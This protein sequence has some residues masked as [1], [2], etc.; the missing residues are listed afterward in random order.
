MIGTNSNQELR[1]D[2]EYMS[3][4]CKRRAVAFRAVFLTERSGRYPRLAR[5]LLPLLL[6][7]TMPMGLTAQTTSVVEGTVL[8]PLG[9]GIVGAEITLS[10]P[11]LPREIKIFSNMTGSY[12]VPGVQPGVYQLHAAK[13]GFAVQVYQGLVVTVNQVL[14]FDIVLVV[15]DLQ[16][17]VTVSA[18]GPLLETASSSSGAT[19]LPQQIEQMPIN[20]RNY[21]DLL[22]LVPGVAINRLPAH[23][24]R[25]PGVP[26]PHLQ[27]VSAPAQE[28]GIRGD[29][30]RPRHL[31]QDSR[32]S[33]WDYHGA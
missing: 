13:T 16:A 4:E 12:R 11:V 1:A 33:R 14:T 6:A 2:A 7:L 10:G 8:D 30:S 15:N 5:R 18:N 3:A 25:R 20:G 21:L 26:R 24:V 17:E 19:I 23:Q 31:P 9:R 27:H 28:G 22:Q 29:R 32:P